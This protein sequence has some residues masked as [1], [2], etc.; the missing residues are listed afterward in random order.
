MPIDDVMVT[1]NGGR[2]TRKGSP[3]PSL[4]KV[5]NRIVF[6]DELPPPDGHTGGIRIGIHLV[7]MSQVTTTKKPN[8][9]DKGRLCKATAIWTP[10]PR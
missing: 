6:V 9:P 2:H 10:L 3:G 8:E 5:E 7:R 4:P 1:R